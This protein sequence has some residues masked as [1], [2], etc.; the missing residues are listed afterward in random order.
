LDEASTED[1]VTPSQE[2]ATDDASAWSAPI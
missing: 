2:W 1:G